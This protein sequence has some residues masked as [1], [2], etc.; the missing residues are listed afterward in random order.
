[1]QQA[2][3]YQQQPLDRYS[4]TLPTVTETGQYGG[5]RARAWDTKPQIHLSRVHEVCR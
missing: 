1:M 3:A 4:P 2:E 5:Y